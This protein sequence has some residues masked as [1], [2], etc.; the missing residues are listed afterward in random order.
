MSL[1]VSSVQ[2]YTVSYNSLIVNVVRIHTTTTCTGHVFF[3]QLGGSPLLTTLER[4]GDKKSVAKKSN[5]ITISNFKE[6]SHQ[7]SNP[8]WLLLAT[9]KSS[10]TKHFNCSVHSGLIAYLVVPRT[11]A[12]L[13]QNARLRI[14]SFEYPFRGNQSTIHNAIVLMGCL[15]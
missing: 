12:H 8:I 14:S 6:L 4:P 7:R 1:L 5:W 3:T 9:S 11:V 13:V 2:K 15:Y 10:F